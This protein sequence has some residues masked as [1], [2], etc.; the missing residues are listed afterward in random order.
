M[1]ELGTIDL[2]MTAIEISSALVISNLINKSPLKADVLSGSLSLLVEIIGAVVQADD[3]PIYGSPD[4][5]RDFVDCIFDSCIKKIIQVQ[6]QDGSLYMLEQFI[7]LAVTCK[8]PA[9]FEG[10]LPKVLVLSEQLYF[11]T[12]LMGLEDTQMLLFNQL[13]QVF[14]YVSDK[15][16]FYQLAF[17]F[18]QSVITN[19]TRHEQA[20]LDGGEQLKSIFDGGV[21]N[22][23]DAYLLQIY[24]FIYTICYVGESFTDEFKVDCLRLIY[25]SLIDTQIKAKT[26]QCS[27]I[28]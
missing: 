24:K 28:E 19:L 12:R 25:D 22:S 8:L 2:K 26:Y 20:Q 10:V 3:H 21:E 23:S 6:R 15:Q 5:K 13:K 16:H 11:Q 14:I 1:V 9:V 4:A 27:N 17:R 7:R 18:L